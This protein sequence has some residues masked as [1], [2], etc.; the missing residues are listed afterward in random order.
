MKV[1]VKKEILLPYINI[2]AKAMSVKSLAKV[3]G[4][5]LE[6]HNNRLDLTSNNLTLA[7][8]AKAAEADTWEEGDIVLP[9]RFTDIVEHLPGEVIDI[10]VSQEQVAAITSGS[11]RY[12]L[13]G[14]KPEDFPK[15][16][17]YEAT[18][19]IE[20]V[21]PAVE[22]KNM[23]QRVLFAAARDDKISPT[24]VGVLLEANDKE[25]GFTA[26]DSFRIA[27]AVRPG[28]FIECKVL[29]PAKNLAEIVK[30]IGD[31]DNVKICVG[32]NDVKIFYKQ[33]IISSLV[34]AGNYPDFKKV[35]DQVSPTTTIKTK[36]SALEQALYRASLLDSLICEFN[37]QTRLGLRVTQEIGS[38][39]EEVD[40][41]KTGDDLA[42]NFNIAFMLD[43]LRLLNNNEVIINFGGPQAPAVFNEDHYRYLV[44]PLRQPG[45]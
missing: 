44:L 26:S 9:P 6:A 13:M 4:I 28:K 31:D 8:Q 38:M 36:K 3:D 24:L 27:N 23:L 37:I 34:M 21:L 14:F 29:I 18:K 33:F 12:Q 7:I 22:F 40:V 30:I 43:P 10:E 25:L 42:V 35:F 16:K 1:T 5:L 2:V 11:A 20:N 15:P 32:K 39:M 41:Q 17:N 19:Y 45:A